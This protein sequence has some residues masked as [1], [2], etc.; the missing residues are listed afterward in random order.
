[1]DPDLRQWTLSERPDVR[2]ETTDQ[3]VGGSSPSERAT[4]SQVRATFSGVRGGLLA[5]CGLED[6]VA[7]VV[8]LRLPPQGRDETVAILTA[9]A[10]HCGAS[11]VNRKLAAVA[12]FY[13]FHARHGV[14]AGEV[15]RVMQ[16]PGRGYPGT[17]FRP[18]LYLQC[19]VP[20]RSK[21][22]GRGARA[23]CVTWDAI[24]RLHQAGR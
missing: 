5:C 12:S 13:R 6:A 24:M 19:G 22:G 11:T 16:A 4:Y 9:Q 23:P 18:F 15:L 1:V 10:H 2:H 3:K 17:A 21:L 14:K 20:P 7:F 8:W